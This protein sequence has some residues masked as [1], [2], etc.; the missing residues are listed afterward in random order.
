MITK[1]RLGGAG[2]LSTVVAFREA[3]PDVLEVE[4]TR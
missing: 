4:L 2:G 1:N 3:M